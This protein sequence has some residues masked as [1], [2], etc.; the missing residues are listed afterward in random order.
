VSDE[1]PE[2]ESKPGNPLENNTCDGDRP[3]SA[4]ATIVRT[5]AGPER[6]AIKEFAH[7]LIITA[8]GAATSIITALVLFLI[9][10]TFQVSIYTWMVWFVF[11]VGALL[12]GFAASGG[13]Y[14]GARYFG[15]R[16]TRQILLNMVA[17]SVGA[18]FLV[19]WL[20]FRFMEVDG[21]P[22][23]EQVSFWVYLDFLFRHQSVQF[24]WGAADAASTGELGA[25]GY[26]YALLQ[27]VG[28]ALGGVAVF[29]W[30]SLL[31]YCESCSRYFSALGKQERFADDPHAF[32]S[33]LER[34]AAAFDTGR[35]QDA[36]SQHTT[37]EE[38]GRRKKGRFMSVLDLR[39]C[40]G[41]GVRWL[42]FSAREWA[43]N[44]W[45]EIK[46]SKLSGLHKEPLNLPE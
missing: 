1:K 45:K 34:V 33:V 13:Y 12:A 23:S 29:R 21:R 35:L 17:V 8:S 25:W 14:L 20:G 11:P 5:A 37:P 27:V 22:I 36:I 3:F 9:E 44:C 10:R 7:D 28:F 24:S 18:F 38:P 41:C 32:A 31:P 39:F 6:T 30:L 42:G 2:L 26:L 15:Y 40:S 16:P 19:H 46:G 43:G 4:G